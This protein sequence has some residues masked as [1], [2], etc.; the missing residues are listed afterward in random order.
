MS[1]PLRI[2]G[3][4][5]RPMMRRSA[6]PRPDSLCV[7]TSLPV[8]SR[9]QVG[10]VDEQRRAVRR[11]ARCQSPLPIL[12]RISAS[13][14][15][16][17]GMR[18]SASA[19]HISATP[20][21]ERQRELL[22]QALHQPGAAGRALALA[23]RLRQPPRQRLRGHA[24]RLVHAR[25]GQQR[26]QGLG[27]GTAV[28]RGD[29]LAQ[30][31]A[32]QRRG[33]DGCVR[34][35]Q[36]SARSVAWRVRRE[37]G[38]GRAPAP[39]LGSNAAGVNGRRGRQGARAPSCR[40][41]A[42]IGP[43]RT[44]SVASD[45][46]AQPTSTPETWRDPG[47]HSRIDPGRRPG[48]AD[49]GRRQADALHPHPAADAAGGPGLQRP[50]GTGD[51]RLRPREDPDRHRRHH[52]QARPAEAADRRA[53]R[54]RRAVRGVRRDHA[55]RADPAD[56]A[57]HRVLPPARLR[58][59]RRLRRRLVDGCVQGHRRGHR[60]RQAAARAG[61]LPE[62]RAEQPGAHLCRAHHRRH[63]LRGDGGC[64][65]RRPRDASPSW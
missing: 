44:A 51:R 59:H 60:H 28:G 26:R 63:R 53:H 55:R 45:G 19:R 24:L 25:L 3:S 48:G 42:T 4:P 41:R 34:F 47:S 20:S 62:V 37:A 6:A 13:R 7:A 16:A 46:R 38:R 43:A 9:P 23:Q 52:R 32:R 64:G 35:G 21:C 12:S 40:M 49:E 30:R 39:M 2:S 10:G 14:V 29:G 22:Q 58:C 8:S 15:A 57:R 1:T 5:P 50:A 33:E 27:L 61:R 11:D 17:S 18:S 31:R 65:H 54:R 56:R 36:S